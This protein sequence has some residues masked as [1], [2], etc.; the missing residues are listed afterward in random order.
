M[1]KQTKVAQKVLKNSAKNFDVI[2]KRSAANWKLQWII[3]GGTTEF[4]WHKSNYRTTHAVGYLLQIFFC[5]IP[6]RLQCLFGGALG[7]WKNSIDVEGVGWDGN[8]WDVFLK[9][10]CAANFLRILINFSLKCSSAAGKIILLNKFNESFSKKVN[11]LALLGV[12]M[13]WKLK[14]K[15]DMKI[16]NEIRRFLMKWQKFSS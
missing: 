2:R 5:W 10:N 4:L 14:E 11:V 13:I 8:W 12:Q 7:N 16:I 9:R 6:S 15:F 3:F 1:R